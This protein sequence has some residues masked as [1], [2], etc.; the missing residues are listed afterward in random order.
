MKVCRLENVG[1]YSRAILN[2]YR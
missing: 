2:N 1:K